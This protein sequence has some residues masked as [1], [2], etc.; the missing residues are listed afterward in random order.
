MSD[1][2]TS[3][4]RTPELPIKPD[5]RERATQTGPASTVNRED[6]DVGL[7]LDRIVWDPEYRREVIERLASQVSDPGY[8]DKP[9]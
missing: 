2:D 9:G 5:Q 3:V 1:V 4:G 8:A 7:D 6:R